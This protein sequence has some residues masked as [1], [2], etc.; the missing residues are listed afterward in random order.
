MAALFS[1][2]GMEA[3]FDLMPLLGVPDVD[4]FRSVVAKLSSEREIL[5]R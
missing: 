2:I 4:K 1:L 3:S 5:A